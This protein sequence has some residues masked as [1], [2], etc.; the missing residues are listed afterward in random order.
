M[1]D[2][3]ILLIPR[4]MIGQMWPHVAPFIM[5]GLATSTEITIKQLVDDLVTGDD[6]LWTIMDGKQLVGAFVTARFID[7]ITAEPFVGVYALGGNGLDRWGK[8]LGDT[9]AEHARST[10]AAKVRFTGRDAWCRV[11]PTYT[12]TGRYGAEAIFERAV[13]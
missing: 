13:A 12:I 5:M 10:G 6:T 8:L 7:D 1:S 9:M 2:P 11:L 4:T 3:K